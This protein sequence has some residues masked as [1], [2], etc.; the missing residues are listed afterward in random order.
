MR[1]FLRNLLAF[2]LALLALCAGVETFLLTRANEFSYKC[3]YADRRAGSIETLVIGNSHA[4][5]AIDPQAMAPGVFNM[6]TSGGNQY[7]SAALAER[8]IPRLPNLRRVVFT[9]SYNMQYDS[10]EHDCLIAPRADRRVV[11]TYRCMY[12]K[13][14]GIHP[15]G[16]VPYYYWP[17]LL[18]S[19]FDIKRR[20]L[21]RRGG[22]PP[23]W[24]QL[25]HFAV[26]ATGKHRGW[27]LRK[28][29][30]I[31]D[32]RSP[33]AAQARAEGIANLRRIAKACASRGVRLIVITTPCYRTYTDR[34]TPRGLAEMRACVDTMRALCPRL[35]YH[36]YMRDPRFAADS[37][38]Y[39]ASHM[40][41]EGALLFSRTLQDEALGPHARKP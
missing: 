29:P 36:D 7:H 20:L 30:T 38:F 2:A 24:T 31:V 34:L 19:S 35:E 41:H 16:A 3:R 33:S 12:E 37:L 22:P 18:H 17:E 9:L 27:R 39:D 1:R 6:A 5:H 23:M 4:L 25:G 28:L 26:P 14:M 21:R 15:S 11:D 8:Y 10:F 13:Y 40:T 32:Y